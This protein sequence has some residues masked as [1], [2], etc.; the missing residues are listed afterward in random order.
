MTGKDNACK[1]NFETALMNVDSKKVFDWHKRP[2]AFEVLSPPWLPVKVI[3]KKGGIANGDSVC[4][5][6]PVGPISVRWNLAHD[7]YIE[8]KQF[9]D[10]Q[11]E[12][13]FSSWRHTHR[14]IGQPAGCLL[15]D[16][17]EFGL[18]A[19]FITEP[20]LVSTVS[21]ELQRLFRYRSEVLQNLFSK[22]E[23][24]VKSMNVLVTGSHGLIGSS[25][26][27]YLTSLGHK[28]KR[29]LRSSADA[30]VDDI[31]WDQK[32]LLTPTELQGIDIVIHLAGESIASGRWD[33]SK[34]KAMQDSRVNSTRLLCESISRLDDAP[35]AMLCA[36]AIGYYGD[37]GT[38]ELEET[39]LA[40][41]S[42]LSHLCQDWENA[43]RAIQERNVR[44]VN[45]RFGVVLSPKGGALAQ[46]LPPF[47]FGAGGNIGSGKQ[48]MSWIAI[49]DVVNA[50]CHCLNNNTVSGPVNLVAPKPVTNAEF[51]KA[52]GRVLNRPTFFPVPEFAA[53][54]AFGEMADELLLN[55]CRVKPT[56]L[57]NSGYQF[58]YPDI[59]SAL[60]HILGK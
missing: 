37:G 35:Q 51:T 11:I 53:R 54:L 50:I 16:E 23:Q 46:M 31:V 9:Q 33:E 5:D 30:N 22:P 26:T 59:N 41:N 27:P 10:Y 15:E 42:F 56:K 60:R 55:S 18:P 8:S 3:S 47:K 39:A 12:G 52:M 2:G 29:L 28:V 4:L 25:L 7:N 17:I 38:K 43:T 6:I 36:S 13:P 34:K 40:G 49:D 24:E 21:N 20:L 48:Y 44:V 45:L 57:I 58:L 32:R 14:F 19:A 1:L